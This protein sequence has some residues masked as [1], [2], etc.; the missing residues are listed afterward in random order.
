MSIV[1][2][3]SDRFDESKSHT[4][5]PMSVSGPSFF[6]DSVFVS[7]S[8]VAQDDVK[9]IGMCVQSSTTNHNERFWIGPDSR[10]VFL[11]DQGKIEVGGSRAD[12][13]SSTHIGDKLVGKGKRAYTRTSEEV[14]FSMTTDQFYKICS[15]DT[16]EF[17]IYGQRAS[18]EFVLEEDHVKKLKVLYNKAVDAN[19]FAGVE[20]ELKREAKDRKMKFFKVAAGVIFALYVLG[21]LA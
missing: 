9:A 18:K 21:Q 19:R 1:E 13:D 6:S 10:A 3:K 12:F 14:I 17:K 7:W 15:S 11:A 20:E 4:I 16:V 8:T 5:S 2:T